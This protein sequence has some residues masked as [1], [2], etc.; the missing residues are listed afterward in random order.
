MLRA[1]KC[2]VNY[3]HRWLSG[4]V[5]FP[6]SST[7]CAALED[8]ID[9]VAIPRRGKVPVIEKTPIEKTSV[10]KTPTQ[11]EMDTSTIQ[12]AVCNIIVILSM[13]LAGS[14]LIGLCV[15]SLYHL[16]RLLVWG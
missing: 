5:F 1:I 15:L 14:A 6:V 12:T 10:E 16:F 13:W 3:I 11:T 4:M 9:M 2:T 7:L 8:T